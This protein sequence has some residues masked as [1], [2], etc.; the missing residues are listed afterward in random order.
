MRTVRPIRYTVSLQ[1]HM[2]ARGPQYI[3]V[4][5]AI[6]L[7]ANSS[8]TF[9]YQASADIALGQIIEVPFGPRPIQAVVVAVKQPKPGYKTKAII[10]SRGRQAL[11]P[12]QL[13]FAA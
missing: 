11:S 9:T 1:P 12:T 2:K 5:P 8:Q 13:H 3:E 10:G 7:P 4:A 6:P